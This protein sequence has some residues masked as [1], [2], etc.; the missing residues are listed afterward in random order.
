MICFKNSST[1]RWMFW[2]EFLK[3]LYIL[4]NSM[5]MIMTARRRK[6]CHKSNYYDLKRQKSIKF[7]IASHWAVTR[8]NRNYKVISNCNNNKKVCLILM[9]SHDSR[10][11]PNY[12]SI[13]YL[14]KWWKTSIFL[15]NN[16]IIRW[17]KKEAHEKFWNIIYLLS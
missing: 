4:W 5:K 16:Y 2:R 10:A 3:N 12:V 15:G 7:I 9:S 17:N 8:V 11:K 14:I 6:N 1:I 13:H